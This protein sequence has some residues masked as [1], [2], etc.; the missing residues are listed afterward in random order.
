MGAH[1]PAVCFQAATLA[2]ERAADPLGHRLID[3]KP[4]RDLAHALGPSRLVQLRPDQFFEIE[5]VIEC[6]PR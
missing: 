1:A 3:A 4:R 2:P 5:D 6:S